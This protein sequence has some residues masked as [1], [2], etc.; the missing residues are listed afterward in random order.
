M[1]TTY[2]LDVLQRGFESGLFD[3]N[4]MKNVDETHFVV[5]LDNGGTLGFK[6]DTSIKYVAVILVETQ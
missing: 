4:L 3:K 2:H 6:G 5:N 1:Q